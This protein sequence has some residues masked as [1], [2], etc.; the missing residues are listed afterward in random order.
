MKIGTSNFLFIT[1]VDPTVETFMMTI[2]GRSRDGGEVTDPAVRNLATQCLLTFLQ[3]NVWNKYGAM[4]SYYQAVDEYNEKAAAQ[5]R[6]VVETFVSYIQACE[7]REH[8]IDAL[9][10]LLNFCKVDTNHL[11]KVCDVALPLLQERVKSGTII[12]QFVSIQIVL[13]HFEQVLADWLFGGI[14][15][16]QPFVCKILLDASRVVEGD[17]P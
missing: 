6:N 3:A 1:P 15:A 8:Q 12:E 7:D 5:G 10:L 17:G 4:V 13:Q 2:E 11:V 14:A 16:C 9:I